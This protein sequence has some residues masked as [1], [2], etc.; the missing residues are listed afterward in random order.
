VVGKKLLNDKRAVEG[1][2]FKLLIM[3]I[4][5]GIITP[6][7][8]AGFSSYNRTRMERDLLENISEFESAARQV[9][10]GGD[11]ASTEITFN[12]RNTL[13]N[14]L[15]WVE[16]GDG[17]DGVFYSTVRYQLSSKDS[18]DSIVF[19]NPNIP[20]TS[21]SNSPLRMEPGMYTVILEHIV[22]GSKSF[23]IVRFPGE[24]IDYEM[25]EGID[26]GLEL[27]DMAIY[28][29]DIEP[30]IT[31]IDVDGTKDEIKLTI[32]VGNEGAR[33][34]G[35][36]N[37]TYEELYQGSR[38][39][40]LERKEI[41]NIPSH[42]EW[43]ED[44]TVYLDY[45]HIFKVVLD[46]NEMVQEVRGLNNQAEWVYEY[47]PLVYMQGPTSG[48]GGTK[49]PIA[50]ISEKY[51]DHVVAN[52]VN[53]TINYYSKQTDEFYHVSDIE[54][55]NTLILV[56]GPL[57]NS[58]TEDLNNMTNDFSHGSNVLWGYLY[59][60]RQ[61][62]NKQEV[63]N[64]WW[65][66][67]DAGVVGVVNISDQMEVTTNGVKNDWDKYWESNG[68][69][70]FHTGYSL[71]HPADFYKGKKF[72]TIWG[73]GI[74]GTI[75][76]AKEFNESLGEKTNPLN[77]D[78]YVKTYHDDALGKWYDQE[79]VTKHKYLFQDD[80]EF[81]MNREI[82][83]AI[84]NYGL[85]NRFIDISG[86]EELVLQTML[87]TILEDEAISHQ[88]YEP[89][90]WVKGFYRDLLSIFDM[91]FSPVTRSNAF[92]PIE[93]GEDLIEYTEILIE[94][95]ENENIDITPYLAKYGLTANDVKELEIDP[96]HMLGNLLKFFDYIEKI[97]SKQ[98]VK[99]IEGEAVK[100]IDWNIIFEPP[101]LKVA[102]KQIEFEGGRLSVK[103]ELEFETKSGLVEVDGEGF[104]FL[105]G[106][107]SLLAI[108]GDLCSLY[109]D[110]NTFN[111]NYREDG[112]LKITE[113]VVGLF[114]T[115]INLFQHGKEFLKHFFDFIGGVIKNIADKIS[116]KINQIINQATEKLLGTIAKVIALAAATLS[117]VINV[118]DLL[119]NVADYIFSYDA[120]KS[121]TLWLIIIGVLSVISSG[122]L[123]IAAA[124]AFVVAVGTTGVI[125]GTIASILATMGIIAGGTA[126]TSWT[127]IGA[128]VGIIALLAMLVYLA[129]QLDAAKKEVE[130]SITPIFN[131]LMNM[132]ESLLNM[133]HSKILKTAKSYGKVALLANVI[134]DSTSDPFM[135]NK[136]DS[137]SI[138]AQN[139]RVNYTNMANTI[140][141]GLSNL[142]KII[143][144]CLYYHD[145]NPDTN[146]E[147]TVIAHA[148]GLECV[149]L[150]YMGLPIY[151][152]NY[153][154]MHRA[155]WIYPGDT[156]I[157]STKMAVFDE[158]TSDTHDVFPGK[159]I[160]LN[161]N[162][163]PPIPT[164]TTRDATWPEGYKY[165]RDF[166]VPL[167]KIDKHDTAIDSAVWDAFADDFNNDGNIDFVLAND[168]NSLSLHYGKGYGYFSDPTFIE[169]PGTPSNIIGKDLD[170]DYDVDIVITSVTGNF[171]SI[172]Y[173]D[174]FGDFTEFTK[175]PK[176]G[177][178]PGC[179]DIEDLDNDN[180][181]DIILGNKGDN[182][183]T[184]LYGDQ[185]GLFEESETIN[186]NANPVDLCVFDINNDGRKDIVSLIQ[187]NSEIIIIENNGFRSYSTPTS[188]P[189]GDWPYR[190]EHGDLD[191]D[192]FD[193]DFIV[194]NGD[195][196]TITVV[197][198]DAYPDDLKI[199]TVDVANFPVNLKITDLNK[200]DGR[201]DVIVASKGGDNDNK[202]TV[203][204]LRWHQNLF[205]PGRTDFEMG[206]YPKTILINDYNFDG[207]YDILSINNGAL[208]Y[209]MWYGNG[210]GGEY[211][212][213]FSARYSSHL[214]LD[215]GQNIDIDP[216]Q[217][218]ILLYDENNEGL[219][220]QIENNAEP[221]R[222][223]NGDINTYYYYKWYLDSS[224][225]NWKL[226]FW[227]SESNID[228]RWMGLL[229]QG[230]ND[231]SRN[232]ILIQEYQDNI[233][234]LTTPIIEIEEILPVEV[235]IGDTY[236]LDV[237]VKNLGGRSINKIWIGNDIINPR[238]DPTSPHVD[239]GAITFYPSSTMVNAHES[240][241]FTGSYTFSDSK[242]DP[243]VYYWIINVWQ[244]DKVVATQKVPI[245]I[246]G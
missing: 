157:D 242:Y 161:Y 182:T 21:V 36:F 124:I 134:K 202:I 241:T 238:V 236:P 198:N 135:Q 154:E 59:Y 163:F 61:L 118:L 132:R 186:I 116:A 58:Y 148:V 145:I 171:V 218:V 191:G 164:M 187:S 208:S 20:M 60:Q 31:G 144:R 1:I 75:V 37:I 131:H 107:A 169:I 222:D 54:I 123:L 173:N 101:R 190:I 33:Y 195:Y 6:T 32:T 193:D 113:K 199:Y 80:P 92:P 105:E 142:N 10:N 234:K 177:T 9:Y 83:R 50:S 128:V 91:S 137:L 120:D 65:Q 15:E 76:A 226:D 94:K 245:I 39:Q 206:K 140:K 53:N 210:N 45:D 85:Q 130:E 84:I 175:R 93:N 197:R 40:I 189:I 5:I 179:V 70:K 95:N 196:D 112:I 168:D 152:T 194:T 162:L 172:L 229:N 77:T 81:D 215:S 156:W 27:P 205:I 67:P 2:P 136:L 237:L 151:A 166:K 106:G 71:Q 223:S 216:V 184:I 203:I 181:F 3:A 87:I 35:P 155:K 160:E 227:N 41:D 23:V 167:E 12:F 51:P 98:I 185:S 231:V 129:F 115:S 7:A 217:D 22:S 119:S 239:V 149:Q 11:G 47:K 235:S 220:D 209:T 89:G 73:M 139:I 56:G 46:D 127:L 17:L 165:F 18:F 141:D 100:G 133:N 86:D 117:F 219:F 97:N 66:N 201:K 69:S 79:E 42:G 43:T 13:F 146:K 147:S 153:P 246:R 16:I 90:I 74:E 240:M 188:E 114:D 28:H 64:E 230:M 178:K 212:N 26:F 49:G 4:I 180:Y 72:I 221:V 214:L 57:A 103:P 29:E 25:F 228:E 88:S 78:N 138:K 159:V 109:Y 24:E 63:F 82:C 96:H 108:I 8:W 38:V 244:N 143:S 176:M 55:A 200:H 211:Y 30:L 174:G 126:A 150:D 121:N 232:L 122:C 213:D 225:V 19:S 34:S 110:I 104:H 170:N 111:F 233:A 192:G 204:N 62:W 99:K 48:G 125:S 14:D 224:I 207:N 158:I 102:N 183:I 44:F 68:D 243:G 52:Y